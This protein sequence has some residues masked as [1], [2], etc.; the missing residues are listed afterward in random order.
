VLPKN[1]RH[2]VDINTGKKRS[3]GTYDIFVMKEN[4][5]WK[6][7]EGRQHDADLK[8]LWGAYRPN[9]RTLKNNEGKIETSNSNTL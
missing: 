5:R 3:S 2:G 6:T 8:N 4:G 9:E 7:I 1:E